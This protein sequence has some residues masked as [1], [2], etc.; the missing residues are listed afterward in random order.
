MPARWR[1]LIG[2]IGMLVF[3][4]VYARTAVVVFG[5]LPPQPWIQL[6]YMAVVGILWGVPL[7]PLI[8]WMSRGRE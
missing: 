5:L 2:G 7:F 8:S 3:L 4:A 6:A 1:K